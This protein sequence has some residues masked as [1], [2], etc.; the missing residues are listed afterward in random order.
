MRNPQK[1]WA[2]L[3]EE[4][5]EIKE[6]ENYHHWRIAEWFP[7]LDK[8]VLDCLYTYSI[9]LMNFNE[10]LNLISSRTEKEA[11]RLHFS[12]AIIGGRLLLSCTSTK[13][14]YCF[15]SGNGFPGLILAI[16]DPERQFHLV[17][18]DNRKTIFLKHVINRMELKNCHVHH[19]RIED[20]PPASVHCVV[21]R[22]LGNISQNLLRAH[23]ICA[24]ES[25]YFHFKGSSWVKEVSEIPIQICSLWAPQLVGEYQLPESDYTL[26]L[27]LT[28][29][30]NSD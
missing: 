16:M 15:G 5:E 22:A 7:E 2:S 27:V 19:N 23:K 18:G 6:E 30:R 28:R 9:E 14:I 13:E 25:E 20:F 10:K 17:D 21:S 3:R 24:P 11:D 29:K 12:D 4:E 1:K 26:A 8:K